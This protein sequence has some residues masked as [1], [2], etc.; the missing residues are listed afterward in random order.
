MTRS[1]VVSGIVDWNPTFMN[2]PPAAVPGP[3]S[4]S[5]GSGPHH[6]GGFGAT[7]PPL[8]SPTNTQSQSPSQKR[9]HTLAG[10]ESSAGSGDDVEEAVELKKRPSAPKRACNECRQ[11]KVCRN[12]YTF[13]PSPLPSW[14]CYQGHHGTLISLSFLM[15]PKGKLHD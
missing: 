2:A 4:R 3:L 6:V 10:L 14:D 1:S 8:V 11:Q 9:T 12:A 13:V 15:P 5:N 7:S